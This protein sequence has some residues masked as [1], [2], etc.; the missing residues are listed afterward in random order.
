MLSELQADENTRREDRRLV[1][2]HFAGRYRDGGDDRDLDQNDADASLMS[3]LDKSWA[4]LTAGLPPLSASSANI[5]RVDFRDLDKISSNVIQRARAVVVPIDRHHSASIFLVL[6]IT[7][8]NAHVRVLKHPITHIT[9]ID[10]LPSPR[11][12]THTCTH[13]H[14]HSHTQHTHARARAPTHTLTHQLR[15][16]TDQ[17]R[18]IHDDVVD[19]S[20]RWNTAIAQLKEMKQV[21]GRF[22]D[23]LH[24]IDQFVKTEVRA[25]SSATFLPPLRLGPYHLRHSHTLAR[26]R[27]RSRERVAVRTVRIAA[28]LCDGLVLATCALLC[29]YLA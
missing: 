14:S 15:V 11:A 13:P 16:Y 29:H 8:H 4:E 25:L 12:H 6:R 22:R 9:Y 3:D 24:S 21:F 27:A 7:S 10:V 23:E 2:R 5:K 17:V 28:A 18:G 26:A 19:G 20:T 1:A